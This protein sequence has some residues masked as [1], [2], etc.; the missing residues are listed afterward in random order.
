[1]PV[2]EFGEPL[3][4]A[5][6]QV[7]NPWKTITYLELKRTNWELFSMPANSGQLGKQVIFKEKTNSS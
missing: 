2:A 6:S 4:K 1:M 3:Q 7:K 5:P